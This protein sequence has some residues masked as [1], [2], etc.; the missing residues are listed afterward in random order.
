MHCKSSIEQTTGLILSIGID[1]LIDEI[2]RSPASSISELSRTS[3]SKNSRFP[4]SGLLTDISNNH[5]FT[6]TTGSCSSN[7]DSEEL[8]TAS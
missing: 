3:A 7:C 6:G 2:T 5:R 4:A 8:R 1:R